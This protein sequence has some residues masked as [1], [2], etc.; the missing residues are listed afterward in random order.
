M[1]DKMVMIF[2]ITGILVIGDYCVT[3]TIFS[4]ADFSGAVSKR[5]YIASCSFYCYD[6]VKREMF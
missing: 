1:S 4:Q 6:S 3:K 2:Y 5:K